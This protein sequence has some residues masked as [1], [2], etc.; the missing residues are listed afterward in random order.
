MT[1][2]YADV[3]H[4]RPTKAPVVGVVA[5]QTTG[6]KQSLREGIDAISP[7]PQQA[8]ARGATAPLDT[9]P[10]QSMMRIQMDKHVVVVCSA[11]E[12]DRLK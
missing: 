11:L 7:A 1:P 6:R 5:P 8:P 3:A 4:K 12:E 2:S 10:M 9:Q